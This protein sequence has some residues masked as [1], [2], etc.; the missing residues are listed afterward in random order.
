M[1]TK[2][3]EGCNAREIAIGLGLTLTKT[4]TFLMKMTGDPN[5]KVTYEFDDVSN[6]KR[7]IYSPDKKQRRSL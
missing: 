3:P 2:Y 6:T 7:Y 4:R 5:Y 1:A